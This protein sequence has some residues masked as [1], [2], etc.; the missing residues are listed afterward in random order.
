M[1]KWLSAFVL[2]ILIHCLIFLI[3]SF[4][5]SIEESEVDRK[6]TN[7]SFIESIDIEQNTPEVPVENTNDKALLKTIDI[8]GR[9]TTNKGY[10]LHIYDDGSVE[11][12]YLIK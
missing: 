9:E 2:S 10:Q 7:V 3:Y 1:I 6:I 5:D 12:K 11:K 8:L 4:L